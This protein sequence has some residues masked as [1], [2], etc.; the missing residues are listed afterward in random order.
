MEFNANALSLTLQ[1]QVIF[2]DSHA[3]I[4]K[5]PPQDQTSYILLFNVLMVNT[6]EIHGSS[7]TFTIVPSKS[8]KNLMPNPGPNKL[9]LCSPK[10]E[11]HQLTAFQELGQASIFL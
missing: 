11:N 4:A 8:L 10:L 1:S 2:C 6:K 3:D 9:F 7:S 5:V